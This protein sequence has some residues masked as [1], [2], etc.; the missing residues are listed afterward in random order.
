MLNELD[1]IRYS[2]GKKRPLRTQDFALA[3]VLAVLC[4][5]STLQNQLPKGLPGLR[6]Y[7]RTQ[8]TLHSNGHSMARL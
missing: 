4:R 7:G 8:S 3:Q 5:P 1:I 6:L 2:K